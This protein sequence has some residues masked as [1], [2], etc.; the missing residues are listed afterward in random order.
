[1]ISPVSKKRIEGLIASAEE[2]GG[3]ILLDGRGL[4]VPRSGSVGHHAPRQPSPLSIPGNN[5]ALGEGSGQG[6]AIP[7]AGPSTAT[8]IRLGAKRTREYVSN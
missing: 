5:S 1:M 3:K 8:E 7:E 6:T 2:Q 4:E